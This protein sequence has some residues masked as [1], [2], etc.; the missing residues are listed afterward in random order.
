MVAAGNLGEIYA[1]GSFNEVVCIF[2]SEGRF[3][4]RFGNEE[5]LLMP[6]GMDV[7]PIGRLW[8]SDF[9][10][11]LLFSSSGDLLER[12]TLGNSIYDFVINEDM[13]LYGITA[14]ETIVQIDL[15]VY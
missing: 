12:I 9:G 8:I 6:S 3:L 1:Y 4:D 7:D 15:S 11:L 10:D 14:D 13:Q 2:N 5:M